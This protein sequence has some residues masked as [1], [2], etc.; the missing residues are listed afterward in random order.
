MASRAQ[1]RGAWLPTAALLYGLAA[2][3]YFVLRHRGWWVDSDTAGLTGTAETFAWGEAPKAQVLAYGTSAGYPLTVALHADA[4]GIPI[5]AYQQ[6]IHPLIG[7]LALAAVYVL[8]RRLSPRPVFQGAAVFLAATSPD[9]LFETSRGSHGA[10]TIALLLLLVACLLALTTRSPADA[11][12]WTLL[13]FLFLAAI[14]L[15][16]AKRGLI[17][18]SLLVLGA[19]TIALARIQRR[20]GP[21]TR[22]ARGFW[23]LG[24]APLV[25][26]LLAAVSPPGIALA[27][28]IAADV[29]GIL[30]PSADPTP[31]PSAAGPDGGARVVGLASY[32]SVAWGSPWRYLAVALWSPLL[33]VVGLSAWTWASRRWF[34]GPKRLDASLALVWALAT[35]LG[36][37]VVATALG[38]ARGTLY[39][40]D[41]LRAFTLLAPALAF[42]GAWVAVVALS[43]NRLTT[44]RGLRTTLIVV[45][46]WLALAAPLKATN[47]PS[48]TNHWRFVEPEEVLALRW[49]ATQTH[50][51]QLSGGADD[52]GWTNRL[53]DG[54]ELTVP[55]PGT[56]LLDRSQVPALVLRSYAVDA[57]A[58]ARG[59]ELPGDGSYHRIYDN[60]GAAYYARVADDTGP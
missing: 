41:I 46:A 60:G 6:L 4:M 3:A 24:A 18:A 7:F 49:L 50:E 2:H 17:A 44:R 56:L 54:F 28:E 48:L 51:L 38:V 42:L 11:A 5:V 1:P 13:G 15:F 55:G 47:E 20:E 12:G 27:K 31:P 10:Y 34:Q 19:G 37:W 21:S 39:A 30:V 8:A 57:Q 16:N 45:V 32:L 14:G 26:G 36:L 22:P 25:L 9:L 43:L 58:R 40:V 59:V 23:L 33:V 35:G 52:Q 53:K 29:V